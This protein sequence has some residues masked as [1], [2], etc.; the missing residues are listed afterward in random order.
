MLLYKYHNKI[1]LGLDLKKFK[2]DFKCKIMG[3]AYTILQY[4]I[5]SLLSDLKDTSLH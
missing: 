1:R 3:S 5:Y 2:E 4:I